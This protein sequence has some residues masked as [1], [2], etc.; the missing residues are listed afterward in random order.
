MNSRAEQKLNELVVLMLEGKASDDQVESLYSILS[1]TPGAV[2]HYIESV[3]MIS[4]LVKADARLLSSFTDNAI[5][6]TDQFGL[7]EATNSGS[8]AGQ[9]NNVALR[10]VDVEE[11]IFDVNQVNADDFDLSK[12][13]QMTQ[14]MLEFLEWAKTSPALEIPKEEPKRELIQ[15]VVYPPRQ[16]HD[17]T[18]FQKFQLAACV[19]GVIFLVVLVKFNPESVGL[20][21]V[22]ELVDSIG[23]VWDDQMQL[24]DEYGDMRQ[25]T[26]R[27]NEGYVSILFHGGVKI[28]VE[29]PAELSLLGG[30]NMELFH[31]RIYAVVPEE[32]H[33]FT[34]MAGSSKI[35]D[36]GTE[37]GVEVDDKNNTQLH[38]TKGKTLLFSGFKTGRKS[39]IQVNEGSAKKVSSDGFVKDI[40]V[41]SKHFVRDIRVPYTTLYVLNGSFETLALNDDVWSTTENIAVWSTPPWS[42]QYKRVGTNNWVPDT[43][44][45]GGAVTPNA[46][47][48]YGGIAAEGKSLGYVRTDLKS[49]H[50][51]YQELAISLQALRTYDLSVK[52]GNPS[53]YNNWATVAYRVELL[54]GGVVIASDSGASPADDLTWTTASVS[55]TSGPDKAADSNVGQP[56]A[57]RLIAEAFTENK[58]LNFD[59]VQMLV[60]VGT[61]ND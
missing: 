42:T 39:S 50:C 59:D 27:L 16:K 4:N 58:H 34:V 60:T 47:Y 55:Y 21:I 53:L 7:T 29:A 14:A 61:G 37:F 24:P 13:Q 35:V 17:L 33:G 32:A 40:D 41:A 54:A 51:L 23:A 46:A 5:D 8:Q 22:A 10:G 1:D 36:L 45:N 57:I 56:L 48:G 3:S 49:D 28:T 30:G 31:G 20:P 25:S 52:V 6:Q 15:K 38:V 44:P 2:D 18:I 12:D 26:Y 11:F 9:D 19:V 43:S